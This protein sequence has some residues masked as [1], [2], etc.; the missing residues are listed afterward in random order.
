VGKLVHL[1]VTRNIAVGGWIESLRRFAQTPR[2]VSGGVGGH[3]NNSISWRLRNA[4]V[5][6]LRRFS[7]YRYIL[8]LLQGEL[9]VMKGFGG[10]QRLLGKDVALIDSDGL[11]HTKPLCQQRDRE[12]EFRFGKLLTD[13]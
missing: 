3:K 10:E 8:P 6:I 12:H 7:S 5:F 11:R 4:D 1:G 2:S 13:A 9:D